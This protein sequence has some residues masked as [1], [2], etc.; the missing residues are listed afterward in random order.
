MARQVLN[1][2]NTLRIRRETGLPVILVKVRGGTG[3]RK[4]LYL[5]DGSVVYL[6]PDG[7][8]EQTSLRHEVS[9][10]VFDEK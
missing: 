10:S 7:T 5:E 9:S 4:D 6:W 2:K 8:L 1:R 3:H